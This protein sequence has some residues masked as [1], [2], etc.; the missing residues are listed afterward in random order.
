M[1]K[2]ATLMA[3]RIRHY[4]YAQVTDAEYEVIKRLAARDDQTV[5]DF[6]RSCINDRIAEESDTAPLLELKQ[7]DQ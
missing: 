5:A 1:E 3:R 2:G 6:V 7:A 4:A